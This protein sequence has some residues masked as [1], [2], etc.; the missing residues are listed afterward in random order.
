MGVSNNR[1]F[2]LERCSMKLPK[3]TAL[4]S[5]N[6]LG[7]LGPRVTQLEYVFEGDD[8]SALEPQSAEGPNYSQ[9]A[10]GLGVGGF[11]IAYAVTASG[12]HSYTTETEICS[13]IDTNRC[14]LDHV[15]AL[16]KQ[17]ASLQVPGGKKGQAVT[18]S[19]TFSVKVAD[20]LPIGQVAVSIDENAKSITNSTLSGHWLHPGFITRTVLEKDNAVVVQTRGEGTGYFA[21]VNEW[22]GPWQ[23]QWLD[24]RI[25][26]KINEGT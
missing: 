3:R 15:F 6:A 18:D 5:V 7:Q 10:I 25:V 21:R 20:I 16:L 12:N 11:L 17:D 24:K 8:A 19:G 26:A 2:R 14:N 13:P 1:V 9:L 4:N 23:F 22:L